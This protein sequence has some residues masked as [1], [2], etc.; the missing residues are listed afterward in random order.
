[1]ACD[2]YCALLH[3]P[4]VD[5][6]GERI[7]TAITNLDVHDLSRSARTYGLRRYFVVTPI[8]AQRELASTLLSH[9]L[10]GRGGER[11]PERA[12][13]LALCEP[14]E[15]LEHVRAR[16]EAL[17]GATPRLIA[18]AARSVGHHTTRTYREE[19]QAL[20]QQTRPS[21]ILFGTGHGLHPEVIDKVDVLLEPIRGSGD[22]N[23]LSVRSAAAIVLDRLLKPRDAEV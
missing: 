15:S 2:I 3:Y 12:E 9:W 8:L 4:I 5:R 19:A 18:T 11:I 21:V 6:Q 14:S 20:E 16:V 22:Y 17:S 10:E 23:H 7:T 13:A 1:M